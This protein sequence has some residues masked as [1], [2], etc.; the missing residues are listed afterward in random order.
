MASHIFDSPW[1]LKNSMVQTFLSSSS[2]RALGKRR[3]DDISQEMIID[4][5]VGSRLQG[6]YTRTGKHKGLVIF[7][8]GWEGSSAS[9]YII[10]SAWYFFN[11]GFDIFRLNLRDHGETHHLNEGIFFGTLIDETHSAVREVATLS[12]NKPVYIVGFSLGGSFALRMASLHTR[13]PIKNLMHVCA[14]N[15]PLDPYK[16]TINIDCISPI[17]KY[18]IKKWKR[19]LI[20]KQKIF[21]HLYNFSKELEMNTCMEITESLLKRYSNFNNAR[22]YFNRYTLTNGW[23]ENIS[24]SATILM[25]ADDPFIPVGDCYATR[26]S[27]HVKFIIQK[28]GGHCGYI[29][30]LALGSW[31]QP[32]F[33]SIFSKG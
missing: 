6:F 7:L 15:P 17:R 23:L 29:S 14:I 20:K 8:H 13:E 11:A 30:N 25:S 32:Y 16:A 19:S 1:Y 2:I 33:I 4:T 18:F 22:D 27:D 10:N 31:Y 5:K 24:V 28:W 26:H 12:K 21:P 9:S 3:I